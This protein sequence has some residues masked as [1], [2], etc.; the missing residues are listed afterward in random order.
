MGSCGCPCSPPVLSLAVSQ[1]STAA[2]LSTPDPKAHFRCCG[3][4]LSFGSSLDCVFPAV[5]CFRED[6][7][8]SWAVALCQLR[9]TVAIP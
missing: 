7:P 8:L 6:L 2:V 5:R 4:H 9:P 3:L 1:S